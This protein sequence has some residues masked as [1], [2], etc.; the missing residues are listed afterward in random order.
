MKYLFKVTLLL[1]ILFYACE[2]D[3]VDPNTST[4][5]ILPAPG[6]NQ[7]T[8]TKAG[9]T[10][11]NDAANQDRITDNV[12]ITRGNDG[13]QIFNIKTNSSYSK[14]SSPVGTEWAVGTVDNK[15]NLT[16]TPFRTAVKPKDVVGQNLVVHLIADDMYLNV[17]FTSWSSN[18]SGGF[19]Y[20][21]DIVSQ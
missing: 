10:D 12:W 14:N 7:I 11:P 20:I 19:S 4:P 2:S 21:R 8:F 13:G 17:K 5:A 15:D 16:F 6:G 9:N 1:S 18:K 3:S